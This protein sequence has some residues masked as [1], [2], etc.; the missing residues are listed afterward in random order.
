MTNV[1]KF[2]GLT[3]L[4]GQNK[5]LFLRI[6]K[7]TSGRKFKNGKESSSYKL[8]KR[9][10]LTQQPQLF[11]NYVMNC[12][13]IPNGMCTKIQAMIIRFWWRRWEKERKMHWLRW[14][15][16]N[17]KKKKCLGGIGLL[18]KKGFR[19]LH[20]THSLVFR[21]YTAKYFPNS[22]FIDA[23]VPR[24]SSYTW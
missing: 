20:N 10:Q 1:G 8:A 15:K 17:R 24:T 12:F 3:S 21:V 9:F 13:K 16:L 7:P 22:T 2:S 23:P 5:R 14:D 18:A 19:L 11:P 6:L 4:I